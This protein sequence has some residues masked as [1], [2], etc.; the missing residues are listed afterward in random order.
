MKQH[1]RYTQKYMGC[2]LL[3]FCLLATGC[4]KWLDVQPSTQTTE[5]KQF[6]TEQ[7]YI[8]A[9]VGTYQ[10][11]ADSKSYGKDVSYGTL[12][13]LAQLYQNK[14]NQTTDSYG[15]LA[16]YNYLDAE[17]IKVIAN[18]WSTQY[19]VI[20]QTNYIL[21]GIDGKKNLF[22]GSNFNLVKGE[23]LAIR[24]MVHFDLLR[25]FGPAPASGADASTATIPYMTDFT[26]NPGKSLSTTEVTDAIIADLKAAEELLAVYPVIDQIRD[27]ADNKSLELFTMFR[28]NRLNYWAV[29]ALLAKVYQYVNNKP[30]AL[31]Y[32]KEVIDSKG[33][34][35]INGNTNITNPTIKESN[36][37]FSTEHVFSL[38]KSD[39]KIVSD[40]Y[41]KTESSTAEAQDLFTTLA[42]LNSYYEVTVA[43]HAIDIRGPQASATRWSQFN[44][45]TVYS[46]KYYVGANITNVNQKLVPMIKLAE[47]YYIAAESSE[48]IAEALGYLN[49]VRTARLIPALTA[50][51]INTT[52]LLNNELFKEY[53]KEFY[54]EGQLWYYYKRK[55]F[56]T[57]Q[58]T[59]GGTMN[60][61]KYVL[62]K[63]NNEIEF[64][65]N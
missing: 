12:D 31:R 62:P 44:A 47:M 43:N 48:T 35:F 28:Q 38:Y 33:F 11:M 30:E 36:T 41:F 1:I 7:G 56:T 16:R 3:S 49:Q 59:V 8:D 9:L 17:V 52:T 14:A 20:A 15:Q 53:R 22:S 37:I 42:N 64:G 34:F 63:P 4:S 54:A 5:E 61:A 29:K 19:S 32:A 24:A 27:N 2:L 26:V 50:T 21:Q 55:N 51:A 58:N 13:V 65:L 10:K 60:N 6:S 25:L 39:L 45:S 57:L 40:N 46:T 23:A 18:I